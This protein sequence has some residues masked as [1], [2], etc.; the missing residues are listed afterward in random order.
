LNGAPLPV[1]PV[2]AAHG[3]A[4]SIAGLN[5]STPVFPLYFHATRRVFTAGPERGYFSWR[6][7]VFVRLAVK[8][9]P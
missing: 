5:R 6:T 1:V 7:L 3:Y 8:I 4:L 2:N 9:N